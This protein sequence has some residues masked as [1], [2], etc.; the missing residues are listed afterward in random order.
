[1]PREQFDVAGAGQAAARNLLAQSPLRPL[2]PVLEQWFKRDLGKLL[3]IAH[4][5]EGPF[6]S[7]ALTNCN[8]AYDCPED[9][10]RRIP[11]EGPVLVV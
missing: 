11:T 2:T 8:I 3:S 10:I 7:R 1:M 5:S 4:E 6:F 9:D